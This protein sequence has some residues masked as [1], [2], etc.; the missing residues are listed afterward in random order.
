[1]RGQQAAAKRYA[2]ALFELATERGQTETIG[3]DLATVVTSFSDPALREHF[4]NPWVPATVKR[5]TAADVASRLG[6][7]KLVADFVALLAA[8]GRLDHLEE[9]GSAYRDLDDAARGRVR[10]AVRTA[11]PLTEPARVA[12]AARLS[13]RLGGK[14]VLMEET[15]D[16]SLLGGF[17]AEVGST[18]LDGSLDGQLARIRERLAR[19]QG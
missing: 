11:L 3:R 15:V 10:A 1:M 6:V 2:R 8:R 4:A 5:A 12:L 19:G 16:R 17:V 14:Q 9:I 18:V 13:E 7:P